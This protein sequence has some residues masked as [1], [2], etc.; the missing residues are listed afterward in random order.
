[1]NTQVSEGMSLQPVERAPP[2]QGSALQPPENPMVEQVQ[3]VRRESVGEELLWTD[4]NLPFPISFH[5]PGLG[6][7]GGVR[8][9]IEPLKK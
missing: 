5:C 3:R 2:G 6:G 8:S 1:M 7:S 9:E 4:H